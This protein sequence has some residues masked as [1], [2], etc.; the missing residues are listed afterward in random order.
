MRPFLLGAI[1]FLLLSGCGA[2]LEKPA[3]KD[4]PSDSERQAAYDELLKFHM[5]G[6]SR[7]IED[8]LLIISFYPKGDDKLQMVC[9]VS[10][11]GDVNI[12]RD[13]Y[14]LNKPPVIYFKVEENA[15]SQMR[16][17]LESYAS[18][19]AISKG[20][21]GFIFSY[22]N[23]VD[24][25]TSEFDWKTMRPEIRRIYDILKLGSIKR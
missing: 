1:S 22:R 2:Y 16:Q 25:R 23:V 11:L 13:V 18:D 6:E 21:S 9:I 15:V 4:K 24:W 5:N 19:Q 10:P 7:L 3:K 8:N 17:A 20:T 14:Q 12:Y